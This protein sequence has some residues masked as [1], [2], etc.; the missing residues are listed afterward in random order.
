[1]TSPRSRAACRTMCL[2]VS[3]TQKRFVLLP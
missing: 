1:M 3:S 2:K